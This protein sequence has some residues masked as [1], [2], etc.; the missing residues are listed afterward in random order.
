[1]RLVY[2]SLLM[3]FTTGCSSL[4]SSPKFQDVQEQRSDQQAVVTIFRTEESVLYMLRNAPVHVSGSY[5][6][7]LP[8]G[9]FHSY[10]LSPGKYRLLTKTYDA[11][12]ECI[13][14][15]ELS[16]NDQYFIE[17]VPNTEAVQGL[18]TDS[19]I[20][21]AKVAI[22][23]RVTTL[24]VGEYNQLC[25]GMFAFVPTRADVARQKLRDLRQVD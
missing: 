13:M 5:E 12:S 8:R 19:F 1:M 7:S 15:I 9:S 4:S 18:M 14:N 10:E 11:N 21:V 16:K 2:L 20:W 25:E 22:T 3:V 17:V 23:E 24:S 6:V